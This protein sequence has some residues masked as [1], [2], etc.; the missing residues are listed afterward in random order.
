MKTHAEG[1]REGITDINI[2]MHKPTE[3]GVG[4]GEG[5]GGRRIPRGTTDINFRTHKST[6]G[7]G[8]G[9]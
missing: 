4:E 1:G 5:G 9:G 8:E 3:G 7:R 2:T 6:E